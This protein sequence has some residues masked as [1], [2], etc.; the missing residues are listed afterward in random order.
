MTNL[1]V[2]A[3]CAQST[4]ECKDYGSNIGA[5]L[6]IG[7]VLL[8]SLVGLGVFPYRIRPGADRKR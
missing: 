5:L 3:S 7:A 4:T 2:L 8:A 6:I 1:M